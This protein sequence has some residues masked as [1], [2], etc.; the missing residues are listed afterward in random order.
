MTRVQR[1]VQLRESEKI[2]HIKVTELGTNSEDMPHKM[3]QN[4]IQEGE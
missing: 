3:T 1:Q 2:R 4:G